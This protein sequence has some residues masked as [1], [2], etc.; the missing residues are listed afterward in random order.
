MTW[1]LI[2]VA[3]QVHRATALAIFARVCAAHFVGKC[4]KHDESVEVAPGKK[5]TRHVVTACQSVKFAL[6]VSMT[7]SSKDHTF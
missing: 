1:C 2:T 3:A 4:C 6:I 5:G 7:S